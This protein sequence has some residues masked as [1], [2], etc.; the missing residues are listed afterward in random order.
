MNA[1]TRHNQTA[2]GGGG[3]PHAS[4]G[5]SVLFDPDKPELEL[6]DTL[7]EQQADA[8][9]GGNPNDRREKPINSSQLRKYFCE[10]KDLYRQYQAN[11]ETPGFY[12]KSIEPRFKMIRSKVA[13]D[14]RASSQG[15]LTKEFAA[16][17]SEGIK[18]VR[19]GNATDFTKFV[20]HLEA[21]VGFMYGKDK[22]SK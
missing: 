1:A 2:G 5:F 15:K 13:Y 8:M 17:I 6:F 20:M 4:S 10:I 9:P 19:N 14:S 22:V 12:Q 7:A 3:R 11:E 21:V 16:L 18:K